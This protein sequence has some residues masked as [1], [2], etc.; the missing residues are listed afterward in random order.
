MLLLYNVFEFCFEAFYQAQGGIKKNQRTFS[1][2][3]H[4]YTV[5]LFILANNDHVNHDRFCFFFFTLNI[6]LYVRDLKL[7]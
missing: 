5:Q 6:E 1:S 3:I 2:N 7:K 4:T